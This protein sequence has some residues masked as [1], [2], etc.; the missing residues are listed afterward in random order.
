[1]LFSAN[2]AVI[3]NPRTIIPQ[4]PMSIFCMHCGSWRHRTL[5]ER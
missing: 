5:C 4:A 1:V 2:S 3:V